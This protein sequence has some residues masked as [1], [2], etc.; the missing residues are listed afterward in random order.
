MEDFINFSML[1]ISALLAALIVGYII[2]HAIK[3]ENVN[4]F[5]PLICAIVGIIVVTCVDVPNGAF[6]VNSV[7][8][9]AISGIA[10]T[11]CYEAFKNMIEGNNKK[12]LKIEMTD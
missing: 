8:S 7:I 9:G 6:T 10:S 12:E 5:I 2:K 1:N 11:G 3:N 4:R